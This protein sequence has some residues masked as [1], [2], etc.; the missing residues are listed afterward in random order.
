ML[1]TRRRRRLPSSSSSFTFLKILWIIVKLNTFFFWIDD[2]IF[3]DSASV[4]IYKNVRIFL[5]DVIFTPQLVVEDVKYIHNCIQIGKADYENRLTTLLYIISSKSGNPFSF[6]LSLFFWL[7]SPRKKKQIR[8][9]D[10]QYFTAHIVYVRT[11]LNC[12]KDC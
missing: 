5:N 7:I 12:T 9:V 10:H 2:L 3:E 11:L 4:F 6:F 1:L 8:K